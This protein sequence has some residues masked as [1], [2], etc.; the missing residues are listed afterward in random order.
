MPAQVVFVHDD[1]QFVEEGAAALRWVGYEV[2]A[3]TDPMLA[4]NALD[5]ARTVE[6]LIT[7]IAYPAGKP[8]GI[9]LA[10]MARHRRPHIRILL[11]AT[12]ETAPYAGDWGEHLPLPAT[13]DEL[14]AAAQ[15]A[16]DRP[17]NSN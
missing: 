6:L 10:R 16:F 14:V 17:P 12:V 3:F 4:L 9:A 15:R 8:N 5:A 2:A 7:R 13:P 1:P 11:M